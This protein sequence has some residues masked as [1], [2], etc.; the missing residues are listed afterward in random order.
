VD[1]AEEWTQ[2]CVTGTTYG[3]VVREGMD[4]ANDGEVRARS[5][6]GDWGLATIGVPAHDLVG[7]SK[8]PQGIHTGDEP[9]PCRRQLEDVGP[10]GRVKHILSLKEMRERLAVLAIANEAK[11]CRRGHVTRDAA[12]ASAATSKGNIQRIGQ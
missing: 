8:T 7:E 9:H 1:A 12:Q 2:Q 3:V 6:V 11:A 4:H 10:T 5:G